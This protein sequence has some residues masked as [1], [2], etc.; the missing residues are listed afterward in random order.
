MTEQNIKLE[1]Y[2]LYVE[3]ADRVSIRRMQTNRFY[4]SLLS[5]MLAVLSLAVHRDTLLDYK[6]V[7]FAAVAF[8]GILLNILWIINIRSYRQLNTAKFQVIQEMEKDLPFQV[9][10]DEW[11]I[12]GEGK[13]SKKYL[14]LSRV[15]RYIP[16]IF[17]IPYILL[18]AYSL[19]FL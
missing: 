19:S 11:K 7:A 4:I 14:Q 6:P 17:A 8:L 15:E 12:L 3:M 16:Y 10:A 2:K 9:Y 13:D 18:L 1:L 5:G